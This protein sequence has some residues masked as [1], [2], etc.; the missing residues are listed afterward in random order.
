MTEA[1]ARN[2]KATT[3]LVL[4]LCGFVTAGITGIVAIPFAHIGL[5]TSRV[6]GT[7][8]GKALWAMVLGYVTA[9][10]FLLVLLGAVL[11][12][13]G[14]EPDSARAAQQ[15]TT[16]VA[17]TAGLYVSEAEPARTTAERLPATPTTQRTVATR[18]PA[19][20]RAPAMSRSDCAIEAEV[21][22]AAYSLAGEYADEFVAA[23]SLGDFVGTQNA[24]DSLKWLLDDL[25]AITDQ[26]IDDCG[27][28]AATDAAELRSVARTTEQMWREVRQVCRQELA[29]HGFSC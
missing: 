18:P 22:A 25:P 19:T 8:R 4:A 16:T 26:L 17:S 1:P 14:Y 9:A 3:A 21:V 23:A 27:S 11:D 6:T 10:L 2:P 24:Y 29:A 28:Y 12:V 15:T 13:T 5:R 7:G 20:T